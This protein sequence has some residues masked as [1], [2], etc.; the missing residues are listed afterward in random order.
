M[1][2]LDAANDNTMY[3]P[4]ANLVLSLVRSN[5]NGNKLAGRHKHFVSVSKQA[6]NH[7]WHQNKQ[8]IPINPILA[9]MELTKQNAASDYQSYRK[10]HD[11]FFKCVYDVQDVAPEW[12]AATYLAALKAHVSTHPSISKT[13]EA[14]YSFCPSEDKPSYSAA[15]ASCEAFFKWIW[16]ERA[17]LTLI[18]GPLIY[19][20][21]YAICGSPQARSFIKYSKRSAETAENVAW[22]LLYWIML[23]IDYHQG[24]YENTVVCTSDYALAELL[25]SRVNKSPRGQLSSS[26]ETCL[27]DSYG[28][29][30]PVKFKRFENTKLEKDI[31]HKLVQLL[32]ALEI[33]ETDSIKF[34]FN[35]LD[36]CR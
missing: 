4:D 13:I 29:F 18:G 2:A 24:R 36:R 20:S 14:V 19:I 15:I 22:D 21:V 7:S 3:I 27:V 32:T 12:V 11:E 25:S 30:Y 6:V 34:G 5:S 9:L 23:E 26:G 1:Q 33:A 17:R 16:D 35:E 31:F 8:W 10:L 28:D